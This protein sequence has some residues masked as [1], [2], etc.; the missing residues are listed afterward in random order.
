VSTFFISEYS[1]A[2]TAA[3]HALD[4][5][6]R[7]VGTVLDVLGLGARQRPR[8]TVQTD[9]GWTL[10][11]YQ[12][13]ASGPACLL[14]P[15]PVKR[16][17]IFD[18]APGASVVERCVEAGLRTYLITWQSPSTAADGESGLTQYVDQW[19]LRAVNAVAAETQQR[20]VFLVGH[21]LGGTLAALFAA[22][23][24][25]LVAG[26]VLIEAP[27]HFGPDVGA[28][29]WLVAATAFDAGR[30]DVVPGSLLDV[31]AT[32]AA[33]ATFWTARWTDWMLSLATGP[34]ASRLHLRVL[35]W[36][37]DEMPMPRR[38]FND[39]VG[40]LY[41]DDAFMRGRLDI[42]GRRAVPAAIR[43]PILSVV[44]PRSRIVPPASV[45][46][47]YAA[48][49]STEIRRLYHW[50]DVGVMLQHVGALVGRTAHEHLWP[51]IV[52]WLRDHGT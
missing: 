18:L 42:G 7:G 35:R 51:A 40:R 28:I 10:T 34:Q 48:V 50:G 52:H 20:R 26:L 21:S 49:S 46:P 39:V 1:P 29:D 15:A 4:D 36:T 33:P 37:L 14:V 17:Y 5:L 22:L 44:D 19:L 16:A 23:Y 47:F 9:P 13:P 6:R 24:P 45:N 2:D 41:R 25:W 32:V 30:V 38:L 3:F 12:Q 31:A 8:R 27:A 43:A 11:A